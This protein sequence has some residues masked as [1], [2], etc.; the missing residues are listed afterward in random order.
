MSKKPEK[1]SKTPKTYN[2]YDEDNEPE[3][4]DKVIICKKHCD[5]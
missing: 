4:G 1:T 5:F 3:N 2:Y